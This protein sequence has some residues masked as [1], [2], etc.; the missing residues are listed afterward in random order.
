MTNN[1]PV[2]LKSVEKYWS[3]S[4]S[5]FSY[6]SDRF[7]WLFTVVFAQNNSIFH[8]LQVWSATRQFELLTEKLWLPLQC[9]FFFTCMHVHNHLATK[10]NYCWFRNTVTVQGVFEEVDP[11]LVNDTSAHTAYIYWGSLWEQTCCAVID[12]KLQL[13]HASAT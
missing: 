9:N 2:E 8:F 3:T 13:K 6:L 1:T 11:G 7:A 12:G 4:C 10:W 5:S